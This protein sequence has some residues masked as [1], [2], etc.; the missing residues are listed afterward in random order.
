MSGHSKWHNIKIKKGIADAKRGKVFTRHAKLIAIAAKEGGG[1]PM[2]NPQLRAAIT[3]AKADNVPNANIDKAIKK[4][5]GEDKEGMNFIETLYGGFGPCGTAFLIHSITDNKNRAI[6]NIKTIM[7]KNGG[8]NADSSSIAWMFQ[9]KG[10]ISA[11]INGKSDEEA[12]LAIIESGA[13]DFEKD[14]DEFI[15]TTPHGSLM[16]IKEYLDKTGFDVLKSE[17]SYLPKN[18]VNIEALEDAQQLLKLVDALEDDEDVSMV[19][20]NAFIP[21]KILAQIHGPF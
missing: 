5:C 3:N 1:D 9:R 18:F 16:N 17:L 15:I 4:G 21:E 19:Y 10:K 11:K 8:N 2:M 7:L 6:A 14:G 13:E 20:T 12:E